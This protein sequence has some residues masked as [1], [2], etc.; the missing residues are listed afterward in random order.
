[1]GDR[2]SLGGRMSIDAVEEVL[3]ILHRRKKGK[4]GDYPENEGDVAVV[5][6]KM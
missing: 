1:M 5:R 2:R 4:G 3:L 6:R